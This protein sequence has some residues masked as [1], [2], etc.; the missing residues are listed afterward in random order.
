MIYKM[1][2]QYNQQLYKEHH[3]CKH[4]EEKK[5]KLCIFRRHCAGDV[6]GL[7]GSSLT[8]SGHWK[9]RHQTVFD[10]E[11]LMLGAVIRQKDDVSCYTSIWRL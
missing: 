5:K 9:S 6:T 7:A 8:G 11:R 1:D 4:L 10:R 3:K 2:F